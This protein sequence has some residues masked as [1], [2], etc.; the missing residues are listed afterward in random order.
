MLNFQ[1]QRIGI[2]NAH[3]S[4]AIEKRKISNSKIAHHIVQSIAH[5]PNAIAKSAAAV[6]PLVTQFINAAI[7]DNTRRAYQQDLRDF[8][9]WGG[10]VPC[11]PELL[12]TY[13]AARAETH[14]TYTIIRRVVGI[15]RAHVSQGF[16]DP[17]KTDLVRTVC[18]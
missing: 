8:F 9:Q 18:H 3:L 13:I 1:N 6:A 4:I 10:T 16:T 7:A 12:A 5:E 2:E 15:G 11:E 14:S 17:A